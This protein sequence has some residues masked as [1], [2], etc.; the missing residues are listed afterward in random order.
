MAHAEKNLENFEKRL[1]QRQNELERALANTVEQG[2]ASTV[3]DAQDVADM[4]VAGYQK[5]MLFSQGTQRNTQLRLVRQAL[6]RI[7]E[8]TFGDCVLC[9]RPIGLKRVEALP[10]TPYCI[11]CQEKIEKGEI[12]P[13]AH[14]A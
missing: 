13:Q 4:A 10:W 8:G 14:V 7:A 1:R 12:E 11:D 5:E 3:D 6:N 2:L 9:Y